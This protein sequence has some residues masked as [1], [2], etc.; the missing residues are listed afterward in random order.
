MPDSETKI[1]SVPKALELLRVVGTKG[2][3]REEFF[4]LCRKENQDESPLVVLRGLLEQKAVRLSESK[5]LMIR[6]V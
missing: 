4:D 2:M 1:I 6:S 3:T 5:P